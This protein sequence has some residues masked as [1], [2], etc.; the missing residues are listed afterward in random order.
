M[1]QKVRDPVGP[2]G[3]VLIDAGRLGAVVHL[4]ESRVGSLYILRYKYKKVWHIRRSG[5]DDGGQML[6]GTGSFYGM[7]DIDC[8]RDEYKVCEKCWRLAIVDQLA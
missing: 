5:D 8:Y 7:R 2:R 3:S 1:V 6:C 4:G